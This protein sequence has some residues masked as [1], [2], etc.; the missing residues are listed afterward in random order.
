MPE[1]RGSA[2]RGAIGAGS[3]PPRTSPPFRPGSP[4]RAPLRVACPR[5]TT[6]ENRPFLS[7]QFPPFYPPPFAPCDN[8]T[9][10]KGGG[11]GL[12]FCDDAEPRGAEADRRHADGHG[13]R[14]RCW[15]RGSRPPDASPPSAPRRAAHLAPR[16]IGGAAAGHRRGTRAGRA[17]AAPARAAAAQA[18]A[19]PHRRRPAARRTNSRDPSRPAP[20]RPASPCRCSTRCARR[21]GVPAASPPAASRASR[22]PASPRF[23]RCRPA[24]RPSTRSTRRG[25]ACASPR[26]PPST[27]ICRRR[28]NASPAGA[29]A[30][31]RHCANA[32]AASAAASASRRCAPAARPEPIAGRPTKSRKPCATCSNSPSGRWNPPTRHD[33]P[34]QKTTSSIPG[35]ADDP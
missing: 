34:R 9:A 31:T 12:G 32:R 18:Q 1:R 7:P 20:F 16:R 22:C 35:G 33:D 5:M 10:W 24:P 28:Q 25:F 21:R 15:S 23:I 19:E 4:G 26:L 27:T 8:A 30:A 6:R 14:R 17:T 11:D 2:G 29:P 3:P 13:E